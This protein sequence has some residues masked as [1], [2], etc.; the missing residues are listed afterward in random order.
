M[1]IVS[2]VAIYTMAGTGTVYLAPERIEDHPLFCSTPQRPLFYDASTPPWVAFPISAEWECWDLA[3]IRARLPDGTTRSFT[4]YVLD[5]GPFGAH[6]IEQ[7]D[8]CVPIVVDVPQHLA[9]WSGMSASV[10][11]VNLGAVARSADL[12]SARSISDV[13]PESRTSDRL[14]PAS[15]GD[16]AARRI[17]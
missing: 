5:A 15:T 8:Q 2:L 3:L 4:A 11:V 13:S 6:C 10:E 7:G 17:H 12:P 16:G 1:D 9:T 14:G